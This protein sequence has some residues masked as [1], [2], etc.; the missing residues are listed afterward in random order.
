[1]GVIYTKGEK[2]AGH[3]RGLNEAG[4]WGGGRVDLRRVKRIFGKGDRG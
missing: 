2:G 3:G 4:G 1:M